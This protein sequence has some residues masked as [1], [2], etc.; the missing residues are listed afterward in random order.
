MSGP[1]VVVTREDGVAR[2]TLN[3]PDL[4]NALDLEMAREL[5][6]AAIDCDGDPSL[7][8]VVLTGAGRMFCAGGD[9]G[10]FQS[11]G[12]R[13]PQVLSEL[14]GV[15]HL[16]VSRLARMNRPLL[17]LVNGPAAGAGFGLALLGDVVLAS[18]A[19]N[20]TSAYGALGLSPDGGLSWLLPR[21]VGLRKAQEVILTGRRLDAA[22]A[23]ASGLVTR[24]VEAEG[25]EAAGRELAEKLA[26]ASTPALGAARAL[27]LQGLSAPLESHLEAEA[28]AISAVSG[29]AEARA[30][31][32]AF[33]DKRKPDFKGVPRG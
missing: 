33:L 16:A 24:A 30:G 6:A 15:L 21:L 28:R 13:L 11:A 32:A 14:A 2:I 12:E 9:V 26:A 18:S 10:L 23:E 1:K 31:V 17:G 20:F 8:C 5:L 4:G 29:G 22:E 27:L 7:R 25:F 19:A 3:R